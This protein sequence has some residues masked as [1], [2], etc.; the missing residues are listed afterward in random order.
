[1]R[2]DR[3]LGNRSTLCRN[4]NL[5]LRRG[6]RND[7]GQRSGLATREAQSQARAK[8]ASPHLVADFKSVFTWSHSIA[9]HNHLSVVF[10]PICTEAGDSAADSI[11][12][13][14]QEKS[15]KTQQAVNVDCGSRLKLS[16]VETHND[17]RHHPGPHGIR[18]GAAQR[19]ECSGGMQIFSSF[20]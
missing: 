11:V 19:R 10:F 8:G 4:M 3:P 17:D 1:M 9:I 14:S 6:F 5:K 20:Q 16:H 2:A 12:D 15:N 18:C 7:I 13:G